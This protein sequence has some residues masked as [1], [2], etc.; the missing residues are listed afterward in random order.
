MGANDGGGSANGGLGHLLPEIAA[1]IGRPAEERIW[2]A[3][4]DKW[5]GYA[6]ANQ[7]LAAM[8]DLVDQPKQRRRRGML[9]AGRPNN[10]KSALLARFAEEHPMT[11]NGDGT[12]NCPVVVMEMPPKAD[13]TRMWSQLLLA[14]KI[15]HRDND[16]VQRKMNQ[17]IAVLDRVHCQVL[18]I[19][20]VHNLLLGHAGNQRQLLGVLKSLV[21]A[22]WLPMVVAGT[23]DAIQ[24]LGTDAQVSTRF[25]PFGLP[26]WELNREFLQLLASF[27]AVL[28]LAEPSDLASREI[29][30]KLFEMSSGTIGGV[31]DALKDATALALREGRER[32][33][34]ALLG[35]LDMATVANYGKAS[36][37]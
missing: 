21:N 17:A 10:G 3:R 13:E 7:A 4:Q 24:A 2:F 22:L 15:P 6:R 31:V 25:Q 26:K 35:R 1:L 5:I 33:D 11:T 30:I 34:L 19:D 16:P 14:L 20:E 29:A 9:L 8:R 23:R 28:P 12:A 27:E 36:S 37:L 18:A 32:I